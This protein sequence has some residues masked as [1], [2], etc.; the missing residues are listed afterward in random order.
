M[1][2]SMKTLAAAAWMAGS[3]AAVAAGQTVATY[4]DILPDTLLPG[5]ETFAYAG[6]A[7]PGQPATGARDTVLLRIPGNAASG[8]PLVPTVNTVTGWMFRVLPPLRTPPGSYN[9]YSRS[10]TLLETRVTVVDDVAARTPALASISPGRGFRNDSIALKA[11]GSG[12]PF[13]PIPATGNYAASLRSA[14]LA[15]GTKRIP[16]Q[17]QAAQHP[18]ALDFKFRIPA[19][20]DSG[21]YDV[22]MERSDGMITTLTRGFQVWVPP[23]PV[24]RKAVPDS[25]AAA[26]GVLELLGSD[27]AYGVMV[28]SDLALD[29]SIVKEV[30]LSKGGHALAASRYPSLR[31]RG[32]IMTDGILA[33]FAGPLGIPPGSYDVEMVIHGR[34]DT[35]RL[36]DGVRVVAE[37]Q[38]GLASVNPREGGRFRQMLGFRVAGITSGGLYTV[39]EARLIRGAKTF[40]SG[41][42][43]QSV[44]RYSYDIDFTAADTGLYDAELDF[45]GR[46]LRLPGAY[47]VQPPRIHS[48]TPAGIS[49]ES[50]S[51]FLDV[52]FRDY[53]DR[54]QEAPGLPAGV[55]AGDPNMRRIRFCQGTRCLEAKNPYVQYS[56]SFS[57]VLIPGDSQAPGLYDVEAETWQPA[58]VLRLADALLL[59]PPGFKPVVNPHPK[60]PLSHFP[61]APDRPFFFDISQFFPAACPH[62]VYRLGEAP[63]GMVLAGSLVSWI[64]GKADT[65]RHYVKLVDP[66][67]DGC[68]TGLYL[69]IV[70]S[71]KHGVGVER[72]SAPGNFGATLA[73]FR[74]AA[75]ADGF[76]IRLEAAASLDFF[77]PAGRQLAAFPE[78]RP[79]EH[80]LRLPGPAARTGVVLCRVR[81]QGREA[82]HRLLRAP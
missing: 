62:G 76:R 69:A 43:F 74:P 64:P 27:L 18:Y 28:A 61:A 70:V 82:W 72:R 2:K 67:P 52:R 45:Q 8:F 7:L 65:G 22:V 15:S 10:G 23:L 81:S 13:G 59:A 48:V 44:D 68:K 24:I 11:W 33:E 40:G 39:G 26:G 54:V 50:T 36:A 56:G 30:R 41:H 9:A 73:G 75:S 80:S 63:A 4:K 3:L 58:R 51:V 32:E 42:H 37:A 14:H 31:S 16:M 17:P 66:A 53:W 19:D 71:E 38:P 49:R 6:Y 12:L 20:A 60:G 46:T 47:R 77:S 29:R 35:A 34:T 79:G 55:K 57:G 1:K 78:L 21:R 5:A 25:L